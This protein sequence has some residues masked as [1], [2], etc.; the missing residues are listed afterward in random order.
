MTIEYMFRQTNMSWNGQVMT[1][2][3]NW[4]PSNGR[5]G[6]ML[7]HYD[8]YNNGATLYIA[9]QWWIGDSW[10]PNVEKTYTGIN[11]GTNGHSDYS[12]MTGALTYAGN[13][14]NCGDYYQMAGGYYLW[15]DCEEGVGSYSTLWVINPTYQPTMPTI[16]DVWA[17]GA[18][19]GS[20]LSNYYLATNNN[21]AGVIETRYGPNP[22]LDGRWHH[23]AYTR[24]NAA[25]DQYRLWVDGVNVNT[26][27]SVSNVQT[28]SSRLWVGWAVNVNTINSKMSHAGLDNI[29]LSSTNRSPANWKSPDYW[30]VDADTIAYWKFDNLGQTN[31]PD[32]SGN[33]HTLWFTNLPG[34]PVRW[35]RGGGVPY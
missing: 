32:I 8:Q 10:A 21:Y 11:L 18:V 33:G 28:M 2:G 4:T 26:D 16:D 25:T 24:S 35:E 23:V 7:Q 20:Y 1:M 15:Y 6:F 14:E 9:S 17:H 12:S 5:Q 30:R 29:R 3:D 34:Q 22:M 19:A 13:D 27:S 31:V